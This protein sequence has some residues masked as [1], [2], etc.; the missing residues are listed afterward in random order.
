[1]INDQVNLKQQQINVESKQ[2]DL[3]NQIKSTN[4]DELKKD[5]YQQHENKNKV[6]KFRARPINHQESSI[7]LTK[8]D[9]F[10]ET[11]LSL[12]FGEDINL[13]KFSAEQFINLFTASLTESNSTES[14]LFTTTAKQVRT[15]R[16]ANNYLNE[17]DEILPQTYPRKLDWRDSNVISE[18]DNQGACGACWAHSTLQTIESMAGK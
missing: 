14:N 3:L 9:K 17:Y 16:D 1:M 5:N 7:E 6:N 4:E 11:Y 2:N 15:K 8:F 10:I 18:V 12:Q 13:P